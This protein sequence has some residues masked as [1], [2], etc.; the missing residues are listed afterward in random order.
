M[1]E[2]L[3]FLFAEWVWPRVNGCALI[4]TDVREPQ[5]MLPNRSIARSFSSCHSIGSLKMLLGLYQDMT[6][7]T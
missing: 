3:A 2:V 4:C 7:K 6:L 5:Q 1:A